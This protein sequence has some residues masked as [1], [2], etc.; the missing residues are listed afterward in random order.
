M[1]Q[2]TINVEFLPGYEIGPKPRR[3]DV[4]I[5][6]EGVE[7]VPQGGICEVAEKEC[8]Y[9]TV[10]RGHSVPPGIR[11][12][13][14][15]DAAPLSDTRP[16]S[17]RRRPAGELTLAYRDPASLMYLG[18]PAVLS[19]DDPFVLASDSE[20]AQA[21]AGAVARYRADLEAAD[22]AAERAAVRPR[23]P[24]RVLPYPGSRPLTVD[25][26]APK[27]RVAFCF[28]AVDPFGEACGRRTAFR[29]RAHLLQTPHPILSCDRNS[30]LSPDA[31][32]VTRKRD[33]PAASSS[34]PPAKRGRWGP[35]VT[36]ASA[37][38]A[39]DS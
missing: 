16:N 26:V 7:H 34:A 2:E 10:H 4:L 35:V 8:L 3:T 31:F 24:T 33:R 21:A 14:T 6:V 23:K 15:V 13:I 29:L 18:T 12:L 28:P 30:V 22:R 5:R 1:R 32:L 36:R 39:K 20:R 17:F 11:L 9:L 27:T 19:S 38:I 25:V 37:G